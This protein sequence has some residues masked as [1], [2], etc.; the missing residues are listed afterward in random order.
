MSLRVF[1]L[2]LVA[3]AFAAVAVAQSFPARPVRI[4]APFPAGGGTDIFARIIGQKLA[5]AWNQQMVVDNRPGAAGMIG[6]AFVARS[7]PDGYTLVL[8]SLDTLS[9]IPHINKKPLYDS[10]HDFSPVLMFASAPN[11]L[12]QHPSVPAHSVKELIALAKSH[13]GQLN[14]ASNGFGTLS[15][16]TGELFKLQTGGAIVHVPYNGGAPAVLGVLTGQASMLFASIPTTLPQVT[17]GRLR[18][19]A[20]GNLTRVDT[21]KDLPTIA[22]TLPGFESV[23]RWAILGPVGIAPDVVAKLNRDFTAALN[24]EDV[25]ASFAAQGAK[26]LGGT[27]AELAAFMKVDYDKW[28]KVVRDAGIR[29]E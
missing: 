5:V 6:N 26:G 4:V 10:L 20:V 16:L 12:V 2:A 19:L 23:Q 9:I 21:V 28:G 17:A 14:F 1:A 3:S 18:A 29:P 11:L 8:S 27:P 7:A 22:E 25:K 13:P 15:H 24:D